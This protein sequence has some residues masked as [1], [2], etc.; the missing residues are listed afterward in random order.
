M[1]AENQ[2]LKDIVKYLADIVCERAKLG[3]FYGIFLIPEGLIEFIPEVKVLI[4]EI[5]TKINHFSKESGKDMR[6]FIT[7]N[8]SEESRTLFNFLPQAISDQL[9]IDRDPHGNVQVAKIETERLLILLVQNLLRERKAEGTYSGRFRPQPNYFGY[10]GRCALPS[11]F[12][13]NYCYSLGRTA[14]GL[15]RLGR[16]GY[17][18]IIKN[19]DKKNTDKWIAGGCPLPTM[20]GVELRHEKYVPVITKA[21]TDLNGKCFRAFAELRYYWALH[22]CYI[23]PGP[24]Q[25]AGSNADSICYLVKPPAKKELQMAAEATV[26]RLTLENKVM[27]P[28]LSPFAMARMTESCELPET[29]EN[30]EYYCVANKLFQASTLEDR[31]SIEKVFPN[32][33]HNPKSSYFVELIDKRVLNDE[34]LNYTDKEM[35]NLNKSFKEILSSDLPCGKK[36]KIGV[37]YTG[38]QSPGANNVVDGLLRYANKR[39]SAVQILGFKRGTEGFFKAE[40]ILFSNN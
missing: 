40:V 22:D 25:F 29:L 13:A 15:I 7:E 37:I 3:K 35:E 23:S 5:N 17:M 38:S 28:I 39:G 21:L 9:L 11:H 31:I 6:T 8:L 10:E 36:L 4:S 1:Q 20:M 18:A 34:Y 32:M 16:S 2:S 24:I 26:E 14:A 19:L 27:A 30:F 12:D 33:S